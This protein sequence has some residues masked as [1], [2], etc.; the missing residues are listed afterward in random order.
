MKEYTIQVGEIFTEE[1]ALEL[2]E[3]LERKDGEI[4]MLR[5][6]DRTGKPIE[7]SYTASYAKRELEIL[8]E[9]RSDAIIRDF[10][11]EI[12][13]LCEAFGN[14]GQSGGS[15]PYTASALSQAVKKLCLQMPIAPLTG[16]DDE[17]SGS[18]SGEKEVFQNNRLSSVFKEN[19]KSHYLDAITWKTQKGSTW[20]GKAK[21]QSGEEITSRQYIKSFPFKPQEF[22]IDVI[23]KEISKDNWEFTIKD[24]KDL[25]KVFEVYDKFI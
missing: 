11:P 22:T 19:G 24:E 9:T 6:D 16:K 20:H 4:A 14:S 15:A 23:E 21:T 17:W 10:V 3:Y 1:K 12:I 18:L 7:K 8:L 2:K 5:S 25:E 13:A